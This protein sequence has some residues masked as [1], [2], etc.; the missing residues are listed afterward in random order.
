MRSVGFFGT[1]DFAASI[2]RD[3]LSDP[4]TR[5]LF[6]VTNPDRAVGRSAE[7][8]ESPVSSLAKS[9]GIPVFKPE[10]IRSNADFFSELAKF[11][12]DYFVVAAYGKILPNEVLEAPSRLCVNVH[13]SVLPRYRGASP[14][15]ESVRN[16]DTETGVTVMAMSEG[17]DEG[18]RIAVLPIPIGPDDTS[19]DL[20]ARFSEVSGKFLLETLARFESGEAV[21]TP[22]DHSLATYCG[23]ITKEDARADW[24]LSAKTLRDAYRAFRPWP[25]FHTEFR[26]KRLSVERCGIHSGP[27]PELP[28]GSVFATADGTPAVVCAEGA[29]ILSELKL[30]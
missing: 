5:V 7:L 17:M 27:V 25:G 10:K 16:G 11:P 4:E 28:A 14:I 12:A 13:G 8:R 9:A 24:R 2:L 1:P 30:E 23:K 6:A 21:R 29:L 3:L 18:D 20:F 26:G 15:Q 22:Q 19:E